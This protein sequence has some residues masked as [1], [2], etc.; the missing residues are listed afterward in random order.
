M[1]SVY[2]PCDLLDGAKMLFTA[3]LNLVLVAAS[4]FI[5]Y[6]LLRLSSGFI[7][8][9]DTKPR[10]RLLVVIGGAFVAHILEICLYAAAFMVMHY[11]WDMGSIEG[12]IEGVIE[13]SWE[14]FFYFSAASYSTL[15]MGDIVPT[16]VMRSVVAIESLAGL[17]LIG[18]STSFTYL[19]MREYWGIDS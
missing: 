8:H 7:K 2:C 16:G 10:I 17:V 15:G 3:F 9:M 18:W 4:V 1:V 13:G 12:A 6:E 19:S 11:Y 5:H 14:D